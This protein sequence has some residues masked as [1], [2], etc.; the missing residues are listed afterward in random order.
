MPT[1]RRRSDPVIG[2][3]FR[4][5]KEST[6][7]PGLR[8]AT[9]DRSSPVQG[10]GRAS[11]GGVPLE[12]LEFSGH[13]ALGKPIMTYDRPP[14]FIPATPEYVLAAIRDSYRQ[15]CQ[16]DPETEPDVDL[17]FNT[18]ID[19]WRSACDLIPWRELGRVLDDEWSLGR[20]QDAWRTV[21]TPEWKR[22]LRTLCE[23]ISE[24]AIRPSIEPATILGVCPDNT[25]G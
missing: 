14:A 13:P 8:H 5:T 24:G 20:P 7:S 17:T 21:L 4:L 25:S 15:Q 18:T 22:T 19:E 12:N 2:P 10:D 23:F 9:P 3:P 11:I 16:Y 6:E 1:T